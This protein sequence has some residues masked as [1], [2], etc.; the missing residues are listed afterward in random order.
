MTYISTGYI[1][2]L[3]IPKGAQGLRLG[4]IL[5]RTRPRTIFGTFRNVLFA[6]SYGQ[7]KRSKMERTRR[8]ARGYTRRSANDKGI[9][10]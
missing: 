1:G 2:T 9:I 5:S 8:S 3:S 10:L 4:L 6:G 7:R